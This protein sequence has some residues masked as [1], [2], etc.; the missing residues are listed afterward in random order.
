[1]LFLLPGLHSFHPHLVNSYYLSVS[2]STYSV[3]LQEAHTYLCFATVL[4]IIILLLCTVLGFM[5]LSL[6]DIIH[7][8][9]NAL[10]LLVMVSTRATH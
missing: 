1:M 5:A 2:K 4:M 8:G 7:Q 3:F 9:G 10:C 6:V